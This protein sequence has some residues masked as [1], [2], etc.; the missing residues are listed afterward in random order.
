MKPDV[1]S[2]R[3]RIE[4]QELGNKIGGLLASSTSLRRQGQ[5]WFVGVGHKP[6]LAKLPAGLDQWCA[7][8]AYT[9]ELT[10]RS[11]AESLNPI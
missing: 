9:P 7:D 5:D 8:R 3:P 11:V 10:K 1:E 4:L 6:A 2:Q